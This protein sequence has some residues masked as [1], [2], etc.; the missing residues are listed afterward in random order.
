MVEIDLIKKNLLLKRIVHTSDC[1]LEKSLHFIPFS[2]Q[3][4][5]NVQ[6][7]LFKGR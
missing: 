1:Q 2:A 3:T 5:E 4:I 6:V 7:T